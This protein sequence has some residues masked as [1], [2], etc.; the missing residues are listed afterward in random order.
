ML[1]NFVASTVQKSCV[2]EEQA[3]FD[4]PDALFQ[5]HGGP[6]LF[7]H[8][9]N[10][11]SEAGKSQQRLNLPKIRSANR[12]SSGPCILGFTTYKEPRRELPEPPVSNHEYRS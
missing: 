6:S 3:V 12:A 7:V 1:V 4:R 11:D 2:D 9:T 5:V 10:F 8:Q